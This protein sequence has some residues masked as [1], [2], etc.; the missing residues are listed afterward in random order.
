MPVDDRTIRHLGLASMSRLV[1]AVVAAASVVR[2]QAGDSE[3][4]AMFES[5]LRALFAAEKADGKEMK[6]VLALAKGK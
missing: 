5:G 1:L 4:R 3:T 6:E 2:A